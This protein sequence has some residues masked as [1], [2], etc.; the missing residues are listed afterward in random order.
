MTDELSMY[1]FSQD[2][3][4]QVGIR[5]R[6]EQAPTTMRMGNR[7]DQ[8]WPFVDL[9]LV[10]FGDNALPV[11]GSLTLDGD[12]LGPYRFNLRSMRHVEVFQQLG[13]YISPELAAKPLDQSVQ[14]TPNQ[15]MYTLETPEIMLLEWRGQA[16]PVDMPDQ[17]RPVIIPKI[18]PG[19]FVRTVVSPNLPPVKANRLGTIT[20]PYKQSGLIDAVR[21]L[22]QKEEIVGFTVDLQSGP[23]RIETNSG[24]SFYHMPQLIYDLRF[25]RPDQYGL[26]AYFDV[27]NGTYSAVNSYRVALQNPDGDVDKYVNQ[28][29]GRGSY[30][31]LVEALREVRPPDVEYQAEWLYDRQGPQA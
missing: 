5:D 21:G 17:A 13:M 2:F 1:G 20:A 28:Q 26:L 10:K 19:M 6:S 12:Q 18:Q 11:A 23:T 14:D 27:G 30:N 9:L 7:A 16:K 8:I 3:L 4:R 25:V 15:R 29:V 24:T 31:N 22:E